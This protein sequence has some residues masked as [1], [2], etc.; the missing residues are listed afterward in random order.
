MKNGWDDLNLWEEFYFSLCFFDFVLG[1]FN[2]KNE[3]LDVMMK[4]VS[5][6]INFIVFLIMFGEKFKGEWSVLG[7][8]F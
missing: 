7:L 2:V 1:C 6:F 8:S 3:E 4:E 5:G